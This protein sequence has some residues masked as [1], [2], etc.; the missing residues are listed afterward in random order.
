MAAGRA[1]RLPLGRCRRRERERLC[2]RYRNRRIQKFTS[3]GTFLTKWGSDGSGNGQF[4]DLGDIA[5][6][7]SGQVFATD[8]AEQCFP[9]GGARSSAPH[10]E[11]FGHGDLPDHVGQPGQRGRAVQHSLPRRCRWEWKRLRRRRWQRPHPKVHKHRLLHPQVGQLWQRQWAVHL[12]VCDRRGWKR[13]RLRHRHRQQPHQTPPPAS[14]SSRT[15][16]PSSPRGAARAPGMGSSATAAP[17]ASPWMGSGHVFVADG[18]NNRIQ[19]FTCPCGNGQVDPGE[20]CDDGNSVNGDCCSSTCQFEPLNSS[21]NDHNPCTSGDRC[22][23][24][25]VCGFTSCSTGM[26]CIGCGCSARGTEVSGVRRA[27]PVHCRWSVGRGVCWYEG[28]VGESC[29]QTC[30]AVGKTCDPATITY[31]GSAGTTAHCDAVLAALN[32]HA[33]D[34][35]TGDLDCT[36]ST[37][38]G[39]GCWWF[40]IDYTGTAI[41]YARCTTPP[42]TCDAVPV[43][44][45]GPASG[46]RACACSQ[47]D[48]AGT[49]SSAAT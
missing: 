49:R 28:S 13:P 29:D 15:Q 48:C 46:S 38:P 43:F 9:F 27:R 23:G 8:W 30:A 32:N 31:A 42:T 4:T 37:A 11:I 19:K 20:Q 6:D 21:C 26:A 2:R 40:F 5:V 36:L 45:G 33:P 7:G 22:T 41:V 10:P 34:G 47:S 39:V 18:N 35:R 14:R 25:G 3:D 16:E 17:T 44:G 12:S 24:T 1:A